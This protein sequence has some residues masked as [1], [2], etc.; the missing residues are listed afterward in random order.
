MKKRNLVY[1]GIGARKT[2]DQTLRRMRRIA[3]R[4]AELGWT[5]RTGGA[6]GADQAFLDGAL[7]AGGEV[8]LYLPRPGHNGHYPSRYA[9]RVRISERPPAAAYELAAR[10]HPRWGRLSD[11]VR[12]LHARNAQILLGPDGVSEPVRFVIAWTEGGRVV[13]GTGM[14]LRMARAA[15]IPVVNLYDQGALDAIARLVKQ[16]ER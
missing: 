8:E 7:R 5:L 1:A 3:A 12:A 6:Q 2:P 14:S 9:P 10:H 13:G 4:L 15:G 11:F 16:A